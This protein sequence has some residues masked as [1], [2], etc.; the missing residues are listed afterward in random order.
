M[1]NSENKKK[2]HNRIGIFRWLMISLIVIVIYILVT[3]GGIYMGTAYYYS[4]HQ[5]QDEIFPG[6]K[7]I[8]VVDGNGTSAWRIPLLITILKESPLLNMR[9]IIKNENDKNFSLKITK[10]MIKDSSSENMVIIDRTFNFIKGIPSKNEIIDV[11]NAII[12]DESVMSIRLYGVVEDEQFHNEQ[13]FVIECT[14]KI[15]WKEFWMVPRWHLLFGD[16]C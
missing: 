9:I 7:C 3:G 14:I 11:S 10:A 8:I 6:C 15:F 1:P 12:R 16:S 2:E 4:E 5:S 13:E